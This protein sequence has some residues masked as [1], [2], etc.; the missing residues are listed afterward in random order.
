MRQMLRPLAAEFVGTFFLLFGVIG[1]IVSNAYRENSVGLLGIAAAQGLALAVAVTATM[2]ISGGHLNPAVTAGLWSVGRISARDAGLYIVAQ[3]L[4]AVAATAVM[5]GLY[6]EMAGVV[7]RL[8]T[9]ALA[10]DVSFAE[11]VLVECVM[12]FLLAFAMMGTVVDSDA[13]K[14]GGIGVGLTLLVAVLGGGNI[15]GAA[16]NPA[17]ALGPA[18]ISGS[19][20]AHAVYWI[21]P[22]LG[23]VAAMQLYERLL[24]K[25]DA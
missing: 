3:L 23:A 21:G 6:P 5:K 25:K 2:R 11:G 14:I 24:L 20:T 13:P 19:W 17:R 8:G 15:T 16:L 10:A 18:A 7:T 1:A 9:P 22:I 4:G 12:T